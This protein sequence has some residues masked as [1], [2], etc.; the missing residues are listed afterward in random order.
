MS[1]LLTVLILLT[2][3]LSSFAFDDGDFTP[4]TVAP[5]K[6]LVKNQLE[7]TIG[8]DKKIS[9]VKMPGVDLK[10]MELRKIKNALQKRITVTNGVVN[11]PNNGVIKGIVD[12]NI[13]AD[14]PLCCKIKVNNMSTMAGG[15][16]QGAGRGK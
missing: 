8:A 14:V 1:K 4:M 3:S 16:M 7:I 9:N 13:T 12:N 11:L 2:F 15:A 5:K 6:Q 10:P